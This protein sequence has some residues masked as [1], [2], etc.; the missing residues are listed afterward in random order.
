MA[1]CLVVAAIGHEQGPLAPPLRLTFSGFRH[2]R[3]ESCFACR[4][5]LERYLTLTDSWPTFL[6]RTG[7]EDASV[8]CA[9]HM[10]R[11][12]LTA[13]RTQAQRCRSVLR[14]LR[15]FWLIKCKPRWYS[16]NGHSHKRSPRPSS[17]NSRRSDSA[18]SRARTVSPLGMQPVF[19]GMPVEERVS[20]RAPHN[21]TACISLSPKPRRT[22]LRP[23]TRPRP[24]T[25]ASRR[26]ILRD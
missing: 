22:S 17:P 4:H 16:S 25:M 10:P 11:A 20:G 24:P 5:T 6:H 19:L 7:V 18:L 8:H 3:S 15:A 23:P 21:P 12:T 1:K 26:T 13:R 2:R 14:S 9:F